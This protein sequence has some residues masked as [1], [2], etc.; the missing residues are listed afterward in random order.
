MNRLKLLIVDDN[1]NNLITLEALIENNFD[2]RLF[3]ANSG[4][5]AL[6][7]LINT[8]IDMIITD[9]Q[10]PDMDGFE[11]TE[12]IRQ[13][14]KTQHVPVIMLTATYVSETFRKRGFSLGVED[15][16][17]K[18]INDNLLIGRIKAYLRPIQ[19]ERNLN[20]ELEL[21]IKERTKELEE[22]NNKL[23]N[24][25]D[26]KDKFETELIK[27]KE[28]AEEANKAKSLFLSTM[29]HEIR[30]PMNAVIGMTNILLNNNKDKE[31]LES[32][33]IL[34]HSANNLLAI[35]ND[36]LDFSKIEAGKVSFEEINFNLR[37]VL[38]NTRKSLL[39]L[40]EIRH[41]EIDLIINKD[42][43]TFVVGDSVKIGQIITNLLSNS[44]KFTLNGKITIEVKLINIE[45]ENYTL[46]F[47]VTDTGI[48]I[49]KNK[50]DQIFENFT[51][52]EKNTTRN[53]GGTG[54]GLAIVKKLLELQGSKIT[55]ESELNK[56][57]KFFFELKLKKGELKKE[58]SDNH[59]T[60]FESLKGIKIL[61]CED[62][63]INQLV[64]KKTLNNWDI[65]VDLADNGLI[66]IEKLKS[67][68]YD[69]ILMDLQMPEMDGY[70]ASNKIRSLKDKTKSDLPILALTASVM[71]EVKQNISGAGMN[72]FIAKPFEPEE[73]YNKIYKYTRNKT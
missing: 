38:E 15:Y 17:T 59:E 28:Q 62:N 73:F 8:D 26:Q 6:N 57:S 53:F 32:L 56:G 2:V 44:I 65:E 4:Y 55:V 22:L 66:G 43:P 35:I 10:M 72:D 33:N 24:E 14:P 67:N 36:I 40:A 5:E 7:I 46:Y 64:A 19:K 30:T 41:T 9:I 70:E 23:L 11:L 27:A 51:Q 71:D 54:L 63:K 49:A 45:N 25:I 37:E 16:I 61:L 18:P 3:K 52:A 21:K 20:I 47:S 48:G 60:K 13:R 12:V 29:S 1:K 39:P 31:Q 50:L 42:V 68:D 34:K 58:K 69:L